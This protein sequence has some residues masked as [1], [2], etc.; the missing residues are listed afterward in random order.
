LARADLVKERASATFALAKAEAVLAR[1]HIAWA[2]KLL[3]DVGVLEENPANAA[4]ECR[5]A[6]EILR[7]YACA[8]I[9]WK[10]LVAAT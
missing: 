2:H 8:L 5:V 9:E 6:R 3:A 7:D 4:A 1:E 10:V